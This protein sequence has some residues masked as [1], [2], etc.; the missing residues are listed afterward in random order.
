MENFPQFESGRVAWN[1]CQL[2]V[3]PKRR[4]H[5]CG[6]R[7][8]RDYFPAAFLNSP[9]GRCL[10]RFRTAKFKIIPIIMNNY[11]NCS[12]HIFGMVLR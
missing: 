7:T 12:C 8:P 2:Q 3:I 1:S 4:M 5:H 9:P 6:W 11:E 10:P